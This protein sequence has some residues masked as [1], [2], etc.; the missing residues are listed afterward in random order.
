MADFVS[1]TNALVAKILI[2]FKYITL[3]FIIEIYFNRKV[4]RDLNTTKHTT[5]N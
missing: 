1:I 3:P 4:N 2:C 5:K